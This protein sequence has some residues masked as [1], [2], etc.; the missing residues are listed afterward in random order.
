MP[1]NHYMKC[2][3]YSGQRQRWRGASLPCTD[4]LHIM[5]ILSFIHYPIPFRSLYRLPDL[6]IGMGETAGAR[7][8][9]QLL[10]TLVAESQI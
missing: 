8:A 5:E 10:N 6:P 7:S 4:K 3:R 2:N 9:Q 1:G